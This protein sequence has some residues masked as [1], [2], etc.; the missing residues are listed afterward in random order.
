MATMLARI[1]SLKLVTMVVLAS[2]EWVVRAV[3]APLDAFLA[4]LVDKPLSTD[5]QFPETS[6]IGF[7]PKCVLDLILHHPGV[8]DNHLLNG[9][10]IQRSWEQYF[11][12]WLS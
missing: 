7:V 2:A 8:L 6:L 9:I 10:R 11:L 12:W 4:D 3:L 5:F 1:V